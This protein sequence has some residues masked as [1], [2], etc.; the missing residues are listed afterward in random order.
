MRGARSVV[1]DP[2][3]GGEGNLLRSLLVLVLLWLAACTPAADAPAEPVWG[4]QACGHCAMLV[5]EQPPSAQLTLAD[6]SRRFFDDVGCMVSFLERRHVKAQ[7]LWV[8]HGL[9]W[10]PAERARFQG[11][12]TTPMDFGFIAADS[13][14]DWASVQAA[15]REQTRQRLEARR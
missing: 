4:K 10:V 8:R 7:H 6:G 9:S 5:T 3:P 13:G 14:V 12:V 1:P 2:L 11:G 15:V